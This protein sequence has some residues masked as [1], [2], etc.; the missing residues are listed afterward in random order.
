MQA[1]HFGP[2]TGNLTA[3]SATVKVR[4]EEGGGSRVSFDAAYQWA[5]PGSEPGYRR[6]M[7]NN[8]AAWI[9]T[10]AEMA[11]PRTPTATIDAFVAAAC[12]GDASCRRRC[13]VAGCPLSRPLL[14]WYPRPGDVCLACRV[15]RSR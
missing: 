6:S 8:Y 7:S 11:M 4:P 15:D 12:P 9:Q 10:A 5:D 2:Y 1:P 13:D 3:Y 14:R